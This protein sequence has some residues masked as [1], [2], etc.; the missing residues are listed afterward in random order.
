[1]GRTVAGIAL[2]VVAVFMAVGFAQAGTLTAASLIAL[3]IGA[4]IPGA[5]GI[6][7]LRGGRLGRGKLTAS[8]AALRRQTI[9]A[10]IL[11]LATERAGKLTVLEV[12]S[13]LALDHDETSQILDDFA[14]RGIAEIQV[15][16]SGGLVYDF[17]DLRLLGEK[18]TA[19]DVLE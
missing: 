3:L 14:R 13:D 15:T 9:D 17:R 4:G 2:C 5:A 16:D 6:A 7:L 8:R 11:R 19:R 12:V 18:G 10:E 1:M